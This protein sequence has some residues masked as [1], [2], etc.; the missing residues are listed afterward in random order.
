MDF[1]VKHG[2]KIIT[3]LIIIGCGAFLYLEFQSEEPEE[4]ANLD[5]YQ[6]KVKKAL[7]DNKVDPKWAYS[8]QKQVRYRDKS[9]ADIDRPQKFA[10]Q[11]SP[12]FAMYPRPV[13]PW[14]DQEEL[15]ASKA[16]VQAVEDAASLVPPLDLA[17]K[18]DHSGVYVACRIDPSKLKYF[19]AY[20]VEFYKGEAADK[21]TTK[22]GERVPRGVKVVVP[23]APTQPAGGATAPGVDTRELT[24]RERK[25]LEGVED[26][27]AVEDVA[28]EGDLEDLPDEFKDM[29]I[30]H[31][32]DVKPKTSY[33]YKV[34][35]VGKLADRVDKYFTVRTPGQPP[36]KITGL[37]KLV[38]VKPP[39]GVQLR[40]YASPFTAVANATMP[41]N[42]KIRFAGVIGQLPDENAPIHV[43][44]TAKYQGNFE[45]KV[46]VPKLRRFEDCWARPGVGERLKGAV[47]FKDAETGKRGIYKFETEYKLQE[48]KKDV[49]KS[50]R[51]EKKL[52]KDKDGNPVKDDAGNYVYEIVEVAATPRPIQVALLED[53]AS[54]KVERHPY[55]RDFEK[56][57]ELFKYFDRILRE[58]EEA[59]RKREK[60]IKSVKKRAAK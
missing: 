59:K 3:A 33:F 47:S 43:R 30:F 7:R 21:V 34:R 44:E 28:D 29:V 36:T 57:K 39:E 54:G 26:D 58:Q 35:L 14:V 50:T 10:A 15:A 41:P 42:F 1:L 45:V 18:A 49:I 11:G 2:E 16:P 5:K 8:E 9:A 60:A 24:A 40:L 53:V 19:T 22:V 23:A 51:K 12:S 37:D 38:K 13:R 56:R 4:L 32:I 27:T 17:A 25:R 6:K 48:I 31:D 20:Q 46:Y 55:R 52:K